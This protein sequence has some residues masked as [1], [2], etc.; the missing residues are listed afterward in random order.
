[1][2]CSLNIEEIFGANNSPFRAAGHVST[3]YCCPLDSDLMDNKLR[4]LKGKSKDIFRFT[5][6]KYWYASI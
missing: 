4:L 5:F 1:M 2:H 6:R 3:S